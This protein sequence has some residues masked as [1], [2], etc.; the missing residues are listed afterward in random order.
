MPVGRHPGQE[1][2]VRACCTTNFHEVAEVFN[3]G[4]SCHHLAMA[5]AEMSF[6]SDGLLILA[7]SAQKMR[8]NA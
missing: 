2:S 8:Q 7:N 6:V 1:K 5:A 3:F 4:Q